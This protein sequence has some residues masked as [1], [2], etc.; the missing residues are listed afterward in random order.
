MTTYEVSTNDDGITTD[1]SGTRGKQDALP[2]RFAEC[3]A[4]QCSC[5]TDEYQK[6]EYQ[7]VDTMDVVAEIDTI[8]IRLTSKPDTDFDTRAI[9][10]CLDYA[11]HGG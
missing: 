8:T 1:L 2:A 11:V 4:G 9:A 7:K 5:P 6:D 3:R 10:A